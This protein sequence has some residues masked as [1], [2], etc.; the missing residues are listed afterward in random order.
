[1]RNE[2]DDSSENAANEIMNELYEKLRN[3]YIPKIEGI[4][5]NPL[6][7]RGFSIGG[8]LILGAIAGDIIGSVYE[9]HNVKRTDFDLFTPRTKFT[10]DSV[11]TVATM[12]ALLSGETASADYVRLYQTYYGGVPARIAVKALSLLPD[13]LIRVIAQFSTRYRSRSRSNRR[14]GD[15]DQIY[16]NK[17]FVFF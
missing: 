8:S 4:D 2:I 15:V 17:F 3:G 11:L 9:F 13:E 16:L 12:E 10:D 1:M 7:P 5:L 14:K 6:E